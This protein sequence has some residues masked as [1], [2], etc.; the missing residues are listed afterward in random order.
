MSALTHIHT[1]VT[2]EYN[3]P[4][5]EN[6]KNRSYNSEESCRLHVPPLA[7]MKSSRH[8]HNTAITL[9]FLSET[10]TIIGQNSCLGGS[11]GLCTWHPHHTSFPVLIFCLCWPKHSIV[12]LTAHFSSS[13]FAIVQQ[14][15]QHSVAD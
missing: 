11:R 7:T 8:G 15:S 10:V 2:L 5:R 9:H 3:P 4:K 14:D 13:V 12:F 1:Y 6:N